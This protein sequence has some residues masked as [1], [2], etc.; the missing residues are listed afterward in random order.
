M[1]FL[2]LAVLHL[3]ARWL[4]S[5]PGRGIPATWQQVALVP[6]WKGK[7]SPT[8]ASTHCGISVLHPVAK[9][10]SLS[11]LYRLDPFSK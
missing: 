6:V 2:T 11:L 5:L 3:L 10:F 4:S 9:L 1:R 7:G 8:D